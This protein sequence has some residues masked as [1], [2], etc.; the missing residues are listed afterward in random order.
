MGAQYPGRGRAWLGDHRD[1]PGKHTN[2]TRTQE[3][4]CS[5]LT[6]SIYGG[7][8]HRDLQSKTLAWRNMDDLVCM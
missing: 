7:P 3:D 4:T 2:P 8:S 5:T 1:W 6:T